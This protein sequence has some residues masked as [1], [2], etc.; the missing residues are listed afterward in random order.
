MLEG[1]IHLLHF[2]GRHEGEGVPVPFI[3]DDAVVEPD[4]PVGGDQV[5]GKGSLTS[6]RDL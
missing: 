3:M 2:S 6:G 5:V 1:L 4:R